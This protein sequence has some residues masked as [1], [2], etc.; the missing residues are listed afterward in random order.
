LRNRSKTVRLGA[1]MGTRLFASRPKATVMQ[2]SD[3]SQACIRTA[4]RRR[5]HVLGL[6]QEDAAGILGMSRM[7][8]HRIETGTRRIRFSELAAICAA[9]SCHV[10][11]LLQD[12]QLTNAYANAARA[13]LGEVPV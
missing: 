5:R 6:T 10:G 13:I 12:G 4:L 2:H 3:D 7:T 1:A 8:Y 9:F 11:E